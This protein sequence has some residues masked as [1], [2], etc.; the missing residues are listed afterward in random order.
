MRYKHKANA[1]NVLY[2]KFYPKN[3]YMLQKKLVTYIFTKLY[4]MPP[5]DSII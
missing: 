3:N 2:E 4:P 5:L 1:K